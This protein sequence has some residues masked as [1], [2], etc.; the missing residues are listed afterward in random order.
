MGRSGIAARAVWA[1]V[2]GAE[3]L[4][5]TV[6]QTI[7]SA[8]PSNARANAAWKSPGLQAAVLGKGADGAVIISQKRAASMSTPVRYSVEPKGTMS[9]TTVTSWLGGGAAAG[10]GARGGAEGTRGGG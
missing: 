10:A 9:G 8:P 2:S 4:P 1:L 3:S 7:S 5:P 6:M